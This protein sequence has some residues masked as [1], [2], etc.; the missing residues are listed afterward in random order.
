MKEDLKENLKPIIF[1]VIVLILTAISAYPQRAFG[2][3][4]V[5]VLD[6]KTCVIEMANGRVTAVLQYIEIPEPD[7]P[8]YNTVKE[9]LQA[10]ILDKTV[11]FQPGGVKWDITFGKLFVKGVD[12]SQQM[13]RDGA[14]WYSVPEKNGQNEAESLRYQDNEMQAKAEKRGVW[15][16]ENLKPAWEYRAEKEALRIK[17]EQETLAK[18]KLVREEKKQKLAQRQRTAPQVEMWADVGDGGQYDQPYGVGGLRSG[19]DPSKNAGLIFTP[20]IYLDFPKSDFLKK[21]ETRVYYF[22]RGSQTSIENSLYFI[23]FLTTSKNYKFLKP[24]KITITAD[25]EKIVLGKLRRY[26]R[27]G[28]SYVNE[29]MFGLVTRTQLMK[30]VNAEKISVQ[31]GNNSG[32]ISNDSLMYLNNLMNAT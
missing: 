27:Q 19:F 6:G 32:V 3:R 14:A 8:L 18:L 7:Q 1:I 29:L 5:E 9:H 10:L 21:V 12:V 28:D 2:G 20:S 11:E 31:I 24:T 16:V 25:G 13:L 23:G 17:Q 26:Y 22:Y 4:V 15:G 30:I